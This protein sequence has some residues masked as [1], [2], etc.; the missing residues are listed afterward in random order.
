MRSWWRQKVIPSESQNA[1]VRGIG[2]CSRL[3]QPTGHAGLSTHS[4]AAGSA[5]TPIFLIGKTSRGIPSAKAHPRTIS[6]CD[7]CEDYFA[8]RDSLVRHCQNRPRECLEVSPDVA[9]NKR[10][11]TQ[12]AHD[13]FSEDLDQYLKFDGMVKEL[14]PF[15]QRVKDM[16]P[17]SSKR[18]SRQESS[19]S[20]SRYY[21]L[22]IFSVAGPAA[23]RELVMAHH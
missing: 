9:E 3:R 8:R 13:E 5:L 10:R 16:Y 19:L 7:L 12:K 18:G 22:L 21:F 11:A 4:N 14:Q 15:S 2:Q 1:S 17:K 6:L 20:S 23:R